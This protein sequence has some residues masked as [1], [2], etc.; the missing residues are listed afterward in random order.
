MVLRLN[1]IV[2]GSMAQEE[3]GLVLLGWLN[4]YK[5]F[6]LGKLELLAMVGI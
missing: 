6:T 4:F 1:V 5:A 3:A 2:S